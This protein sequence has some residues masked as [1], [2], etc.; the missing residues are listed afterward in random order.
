MKVD[1]LVDGLMAV[2]LL[3]VVVGFSNSNCGGEPPSGDDLPLSSIVSL[4]LIEIEFETVTQK[5]SS[6]VVNFC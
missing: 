6:E 5:S 2:A 1:P 4:F 3:V